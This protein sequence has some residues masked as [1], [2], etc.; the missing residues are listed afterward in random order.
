MSHRG[1]NETLRPSP[2]HSPRSTSGDG[3]IGPPAAGPRRITATRALHRRPPLPPAQRKRHTSQDR[4]GDAHLGRGDARAAK[5][6]PSRAGERFSA[7]SD[8]RRRRQA[9]LATARARAAAATLELDAA[10]AA[11]EQ[12]HRVLRTQLDD[13]DRRLQ[14]VASRLRDPRSSRPRRARQA[15]HC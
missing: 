7:G 10:I 2:T 8:A 4:R 15:P 12:S 13:Y 9:E 14:A 11:S 3:T 5:A 1:P 6:L